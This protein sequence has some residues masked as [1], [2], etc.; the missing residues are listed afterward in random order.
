MS[1][2]LK[3]GDRVRYVLKEASW[4]TGDDVWFRRSNRDSIIVGLPDKGR[5]PDYRMVTIFEPGETSWSDRDFWFAPAESLTLVEPEYEYGIRHRSIAAE[6]WGG[7]VFESAEIARRVIE[8]GT[9][10]PE[11]YKVVRR[12]K[13]AEWEDVD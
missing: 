6:K 3:V 1:E 9:D 2:T 8:V 12:P 10:D 5:Y 13:S 7:A 4:Y 11:N